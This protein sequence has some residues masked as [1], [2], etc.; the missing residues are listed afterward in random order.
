MSVA[1]A[2]RARLSS[3]R[4][5]AGTGMTE[6]VAALMVF[7][8]I[9]VGMAGAMVTMT[10]LN[11]DTKNREVAAALAAQEIDTVRAVQNA[12]NVQTQSSTQVV[13][14][15]TYTIQRTANWASTSGSTANCGGSGGNLLYKAVQV[16]V[17]W[18]GMLILKQP[19]QAN[20]DLAPQSR[21]NDPSFGTL[22]VSV[23][24]GIDSS[25]RAGVT[26]SV[27]DS[28]NN[29]VANVP[30]TDSSGCS[31]VL[32]VT[33]GS[34]T[35]SA[36]Q[37]GYIDPSQ[38]TAPQLSATVTAGSS[39]TVPFNLDQQATYNNGYASNFSGSPVPKLPDSMST[40]YLH[41]VVP[42]VVTGSP[43]STNLFPWTDG[44]TV[45]AGSSTGTACLSVDPANWAPG[46]VNGV[47]L[48][49]GQR[50]AAGVAAGS[51][52]TIPI[53]MGVVKL[54]WPNN[55]TQVTLKGV[56]A[57]AGT[58]DPGCAQTTNYTYSYTSSTKPANG[59]T[60]YVAVPFGSWQ[61]YNGTILGSLFPSTSM[62][63]ATQGEVTGSTI[64][65][66]PRN[67]Q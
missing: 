49:P 51:T 50:G 37:T 19:V 24:S 27:K 34:Y 56:A 25:P 61:V 32:K 4:S 21:I 1:R 38:K 60:V 40:S 23:K 18:P 62:S 22:I 67:P 9:A 16:T 54:T 3:I 33:P 44:Y 29:T 31:Y 59:A 55:A 20:T 65:L 46:T 64:T 6:V 36:S 11:S 58:G 13:N 17:T 10:R 53:P 57:P 26:V 12:F 48:A 8:V 39:Q 14:G 43:S 42:W 15:V 2:I 66:D 45:I 52:G 30:A 5:D 28:S 63:A 7:S 35:V 47:A 41:G